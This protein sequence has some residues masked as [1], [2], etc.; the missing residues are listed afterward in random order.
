ME[1]FSTEEVSLHPVPPTPESEKSL[2][3]P[4]F[5]VFVT[6]FSGPSSSLRD[7]PNW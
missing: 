5:G 7:R 2:L 1:E 4:L 3:P 6:E